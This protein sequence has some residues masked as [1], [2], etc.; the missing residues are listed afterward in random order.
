[1][2]PT[3]TLSI[4]RHEMFVTIRRKG[5][6]FMSFGVPIVAAVAVLAFVPPGRSR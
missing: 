2:R 4:I 6:L 1:M 5:Y 3:R